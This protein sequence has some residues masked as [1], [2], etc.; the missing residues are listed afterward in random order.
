MLLG[1]FK[2]NDP[3]I[4]TQNVSRTPAISVYMSDV[5]TVQNFSFVSSPG[6]LTQDKVKTSIA[7]AYNFK[8]KDFYVD[9]GSNSFVT[10]QDVYYK[11]YVKSMLGE[12]GVPSSN[13]I[14]NLY[15]LGNQNVNN[16]FSTSYISKEQRYGVARNDSLFNAV[17]LNNTITLTLPGATYR[18]SGKFIAIERTDATNSSKFDDKLLGIYL[19]VQVKHM[20]TETE[21]TNE[22][23]AV[24]TYNYRSLGQTQAII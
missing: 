19:I 15:R 12:N 13:L 9:T 4:L 6:H 16:V 8:T 24:K 7:H 10:Q 14:G 5:G 1:G 17:M 23:T 2:E 21:Y 3:N 11:N 18:Q 22:I 20:F